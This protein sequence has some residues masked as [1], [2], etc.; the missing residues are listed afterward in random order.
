MEKGDGRPSKE[1][2]KRDRRRLA[3]HE[4]I[5]TRV[6]ALLFEADPAG[7]NFEDNTHEYDPEAKMIV[8]RLLDG[9]PEPALQSAVHETFISMFDAHIA[10]PAKRYG[11]VSSQIWEAWC[12]YRHPE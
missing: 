5:V 4:P 10:G 9:L 3:G 6:S 2:A 7:I 8:I 11:D 12:S 1:L